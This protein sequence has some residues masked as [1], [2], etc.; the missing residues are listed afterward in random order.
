MQRTDGHGDGAQQH[1]E[2]TELLATASDKLLNT[3]SGGKS[4]RLL[5]YLRFAAKFHRYSS[6]NQLLIYAQ[7]PLATRVAGY[8]AWQRLGFQVARGAKGIK[9]LCPR[10]YTR[11]E[12]R[13]ASG[14]GATGETEDEKA[15]ARPAVRFVIGHVFDQSQL[16][17]SA[18]PLPAFFT[19]LADD[20]EAL[21]TAL[22]AA[23]ER[24][25]IHVSEGETRGAEG[26]SAHKLIVTRPGLPSRNKAL[27]LLHE[28]AHELL[29]WDGAE[30]ERPTPVKE[31]HAEATSYIVA[32][33][34][35]VE[36]PF[37]SDYLLQWE[38]TPETLLAELET[39]QRTA[40]HILGTL[41]PVA[42]AAGEDTKEQGAAVRPDYSPILPRTHTRASSLASSRA[43]D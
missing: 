20:Q 18:T 24:D 13:R 4:E 39:I 34:L 42:G 36:N 7:M 37:S 3:L 2:I 8:T 23:I 21:V 10:P 38:A 1:T 41:L 5:E 14:G 9:I 11:I 26:Y 16:A 29:H 31:W 12:R 22:T 25:G 27:T 33:A 28:Y 32:A 40:A 6:T 19:P 43:V 15:E 17:P 35:G 30:R